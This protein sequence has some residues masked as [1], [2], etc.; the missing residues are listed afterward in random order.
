MAS[1]LS[2]SMQRLGIIQPLVVHQHFVRFT[3]Q[4]V[5]DIERGL[6]LL[7]MNGGVD[8]WWC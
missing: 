1:E 4:I 8:E 7:G 5:D 2:Q 6:E 3:D